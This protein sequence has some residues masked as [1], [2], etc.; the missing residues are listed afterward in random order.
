M[1]FW[2]RHNVAPFTLNWFDK[3]GS[4]FLGRDTP[5][6]EVFTNPV[7]TGYTATRISL[8]MIRTA[9]AISVR[10]MSDPWDEGRES[11]LVNRFAGC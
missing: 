2:W 6:E 11:L 8:M 7:N 4:Y 5:L 10:D 3:D 9:V 1:K